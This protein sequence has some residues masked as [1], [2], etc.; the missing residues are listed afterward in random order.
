MANIN[1]LKGFT[2]ESLSKVIV[3]Y[4]NDLV[5]MGT[6]NG[7]GLNLNVNKDVEFEVFLESLF[8]QNFTDDP[9]TY[10]G[11]SWTKTHVNKCPVAKYLKNYGSRMYLGY[12]TIGSTNYPSRVWFSDLPSNDT[13]QWGIEWGSNG[14]TNAN[15]TRFSSANAGFSTYGIKVGDPLLITSGNAA[16]EYTVASIE[17]DQALRITEDFKH[18][19]TGSS[20]WVGSNYFDVRTDNND[21][22][23]WL[24]ENNDRLLVF[25]QDSL[26]RYDGSSLRTVKDAPGTTAGRSVVNMRGNT[27]YFHGSQTGYSGFYIYDG[28]NSRKISHAIQPYI[29]GMVDADLYKVVGWK[30]GDVY[31]AY[32]GDL[33]NSSEDINV[34]PAVVSYD[35]VSKAWSIDKIGHDIKAASDIRDANVQKVLLASDTD[36]VF[37]SPRGSTY[38]GTPISWKAETSVIYPRGVHTMNIH[39]RAVVVSRG[40]GAIN[41]SYRLWDTPHGIDSNWTQL[42]DLEADRTEF[43]IPQRHNNSCGIQYRFEQIGEANPDFKVESVSHYSYPQRMVVPEV[44]QMI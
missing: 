34:D 29:D 8:F 5:D 30:E 39:T 3:A 4:G 41:V 11:I 9:K 2:T 7:F 36:K 23:T 42:G 14:A 10:D 18:T 12:I 28:V 32:I 22:I 33:D 20:Y 19:T 24:G 40:A 26:H 35:F 27:I 38:H 21:Y 6:G 17:S 15:D 37:L 44:R 43:T 1:G 25:K 13:I 31:R 16:G